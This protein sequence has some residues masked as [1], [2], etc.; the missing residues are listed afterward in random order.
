[1]YNTQHPVAIVTGSGSGIG[2]EIAKLLHAQGY[3]VALVG[4]REATLDQTGNQMDPSG[5]GWISIE[6]DIGQREDRSRVISTTLKELGRIDAIVNNAGVGTHQRLAEMPLATLES[7]FAINAIG[8]IDLVGLAMTELVLRKGCV[9]NVSSMAI[10]DPFDGLGVYGCTKAAL[11]GL[12]RCVHNEYGALGVKAYT[13]APGAVETAMLRSIVSSDD[14]PTE[15]T[16]SALSVAQR[17]VSCV[18]GE[19][20][21]ASGST[22]LMK[23]P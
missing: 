14:L 12:T 4:R 10:V 11:D 23:S 18:I 3:R 22:I 20:D 5:K 1:M 8:P 7:C 19:C 17:V 6:A 15:S 16:L 21:E 9:V 2:R 13:V